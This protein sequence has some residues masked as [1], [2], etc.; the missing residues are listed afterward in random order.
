LCLIRLHTQQIKRYLTSTRYE[1]IKNHYIYNLGCTVNEFINLIKNKIEYFNTYLSTN[2]QMTIDN[3]SI[4]HIKPI[5]N[6]NLDDENEFLECCN[7]TN[8]QPLLTITNKE[9]HN[10]WTEEN[11]KYWNDN[12]KNKE[13]HEIYIP[14]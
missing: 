7:Y 4:D 9:K 1:K 8:I 12:I 13:Y 6:F 11:N 5:S 14:S 2:E 10:K 3:I